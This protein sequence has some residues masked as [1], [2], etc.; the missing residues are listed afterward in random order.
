MSVKPHAYGTHRAS[1]EA[2]IEATSTP[3]FNVEM[4]GRNKDGFGLGRVFD[5]VE[6]RS[7]SLLVPTISFNHLTSLTSLRK[8]PNGSIKRAHPEGMMFH[9]SSNPT[10]GVFCAAHFYGTGVLRQ[11][12]VP[13]RHRMLTDFAGVISRMP[14]SGQCISFASRSPAWIRGR[15]FHS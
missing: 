4:I 9:N 5:T 10:S 15:F 6:V 12:G 8:A 1:S 11:V 7:S 2:D 14:V 3:E 13:C